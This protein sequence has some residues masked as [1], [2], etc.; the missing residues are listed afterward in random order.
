MQHEQAPQVPL[1]VEIWGVSPEGKGGKD[2]T[3]ST[4]E[5]K[6][7]KD[8]RKGKDTMTCGLDAAPLHV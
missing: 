4:P 6:R 1:G 5:S 2:S 7:S 8:D 3:S